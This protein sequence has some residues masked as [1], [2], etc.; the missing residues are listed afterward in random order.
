MVGDRTYVHG[1]HQ[2]TV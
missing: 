1:L 2:S